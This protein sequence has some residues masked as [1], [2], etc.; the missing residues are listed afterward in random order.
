MKVTLSVD[1]VGR[2]I[3]PKSIR[4]SLGIIGR[5]RIILETFGGRAEISLAGEEEAPVQR[6]RGRTVSG[7]PLPDGWDSGDAVERA[8]GQRLRR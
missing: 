5:S 6:K 8:R 4:E 7:A 3:L 1:D 2:I